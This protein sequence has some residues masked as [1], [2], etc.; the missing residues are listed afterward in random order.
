MIQ[1]FI[2]NL[3]SQIAWNDDEVISIAGYVCFSLAAIL[4]FRKE[5][6]LLFKNHIIY[7]YTHLKKIDGVHFDTQHWVW[8]NII[9]IYCS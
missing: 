4:K 5:S 1:S 6:I 3:K 8:I 2:W 9:W 7:N